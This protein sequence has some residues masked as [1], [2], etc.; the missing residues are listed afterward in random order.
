MNASDSSQSQSESWA[1]NISPPSQPLLSS[2]TTTI[3]SPSTWTATHDSSN[4][5]APGQVADDIEA[6]T[7]HSAVTVVPVRPRAGSNMDEIRKNNDDSTLAIT[8][9]PPPPVVVSADMILRTNGGVEPLQLD[10]QA[11]S[12]SSSEGKGEGE[13]RLSSTLEPSSTV[14]LN[15]V[16][17]IPWAKAKKLVDALQL[18]AIQLKK[19]HVTAV[20]ELLKRFEEIQKDYRKPFIE[21]QEKMKADVKEEIGTLRLS[22]LT[23]EAES[24]DLKERLKKL[25]ESEIEMRK[26][27]AAEI[28]S[29]QAS[30][31]AARENASKEAQEMIASQQAKV[32]SLTAELAVERSQ[33]QERLDAAIADANNHKALITSIKSQSDLLKAEADANKAAANE[34]KEKALKALE[35]AGASANE[36]ASLRSLQDRVVALEMERNALIA[37]K[38][39]LQAESDALK[40]KVTELSAA[41]TTSTTAAA[42]AVAAAN[43]AAANIAPSSLTYSQGGPPSS[44]SD[45]YLLSSPISAATAPSA[46]LVSSGIDEYNKRFDASKASPFQLIAFYEML[47]ARVSDVLNLGEKLW[48][49]NKKVE[50]LQAYQNEAASLEAQLPLGSSLLRGIQGSIKESETRVSDGLQ[51][52][53]A[54]SLKIGCDKFI[55]AAQKE[56]DTI[57]MTTMSSPNNNLQVPPP[58]SQPPSSELLTRANAA[59]IRARDLE[60][61]LKE[62]LQRVQA[63]Q[64]EAEMAKSAAAASAASAADNSGEGTEGALETE[65]PDEEHKE[66]APSTV[67]TVPAVLVPSATVATVTKPTPTPS[68]SSSSASTASSSSSA[69]ANAQL[70]TQTKKIKE[71]DKTIKDLNT[72]LKSLE[73]ALLKAKEMAGNAGAGAGAGASKVAEEKE[74]AVAAAL[75]KAERKAKADREAF[76]KDA[77]KDSDAAAKK[78]AKAISDFDALK[79]QFDQTIK[80][81]DEYKRKAESA[82]QVEKEAQSLREKAEEAKKLAEQLKDKD[83][84]VAELEKL[85]QVETQQR[86]RFWNMIEDM[87]GKIRVYARARPISQSE[88]NRGSKECVSFPDECTVDVNLEAKGHK[89][90]VYDHVFPSKSTQDEVFE[91]CEGLVQSAFDGYNVCVFAYGQTGSGKTH[92]MVGNPSAPGLTLRAIDRVFDLIKANADVQEST[93][94]VY[95]VELYNDNLIDLLYDAKAPANRNQDPPKLEIK[96]DDKGIIVIK[97]VTMRDCPTSRSVNEAFEIGNGNR[98]IAATNM[99]ATSSRSH[100]VFAMLIETQNKMSKKNAI[101]KL[102]LVDLAGSERV[103]KTDASGDRLKEAMAINKSLSALGN[104]ISALSTN[105]KWVPYKDNKLTAVMQDS[106]GGNAKTLM[107]VNFSPVDYNAEE[108]ASSLVYASRVKLITNS[109]EKTVETAEIQRLKKLVAQL[110]AGQVVPVDAVETAEDGPSPEEAAAEEARVKAL[111]GED[112]GVS[113]GGDNP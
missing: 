14:V 81:R 61:Q 33:L 8:A 78:L 105:S 99:N 43:T 70:Q 38:D 89:Q 71:Q 104:V 110:R 25:E 76:E 75:E 31:K 112:A 100:L 6:D 80:E 45:Q 67:S 55:E 17:F 58:T 91:M 3:S 40:V 74:K 23:A 109:A 82:G 65:E 73:A 5:L 4:V 51:S 13:V 59:E 52:K 20:S 1:I 72:K 85:Y 86:K 44:T 113:F 84:R 41:L 37:A 30:L 49:E 22:A 68:S 79:V 47:I 35:A 54:L 19:K 62:A 15:N 24:L 60:N 12:S 92:T 48:A 26:S 46:Q 16:S 94:K 69:S 83:A 7:E 29:L 27:H 107:F 95:M 102:S 87:K 66:S 96:K 50:A 77:K 103:S 63:A 98:H 111:L 9:S 10:A 56:V 90:F 2:S 34:Q 108:T 39:R 28:E 18:E 106:L 93:V 101:G 21:F 42:A 36:L 57:R 64:A 53:A 32:E 97:G 11:I 88:I